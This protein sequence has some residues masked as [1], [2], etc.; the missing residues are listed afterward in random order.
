[1]SGRL[2][3]QLARDMGVSEVEATIV[4]PEELL[5]EPLPVVS[6]RVQGGGS[7]VARSSIIP[8]LDEDKAAK[9]R[10]FV[11]LMRGMEAKYPIVCVSSSLDTGV[12][13]I[14]P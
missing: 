13:T 7:M 8:K 14:T 6:R 11:E 12:Q 9:M 10:R 1:M 5:R 3:V 2:A 4:Y